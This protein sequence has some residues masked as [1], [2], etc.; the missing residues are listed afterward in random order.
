MRMLAWI[1]RETFRHENLA[2]GAF[3]AVTLYGYLAVSK[4]EIYE[5]RFAVLEAYT[6]K[7]CTCRNID[8]DCGMWRNGDGVV[9][10]ALSG[11][12]GIAFDGDDSDRNPGVIV[13]DHTIPGAVA[14]EDFGR[15]FWI[16][17]KNMGKYELEN[18]S[19]D[20][21]DRRNDDSKELFGRECNNHTN[22]I[23]KLNAKGQGEK[24]F[25]T[26]QG[27]LAVLDVPR[28]RPMR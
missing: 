14:L 18:H 20:S 22:S 5:E 2:M 24:D 8:R 19:D 27:E 17:C 10:E 12:D 11:E 23:S 9:D 25:T 26:A 3:L 21:K 13:Y 6:N 1:I 15:D 4:L 7:V 16:H 28:K